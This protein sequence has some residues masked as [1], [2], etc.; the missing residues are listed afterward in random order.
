MVGILSKNIGRKMLPEDRRWASALCGSVWREP[1]NR[2]SSLEGTLGGSTR[3]DPELCMRDVL[4][5]G[6]DR[7]FPW[8]AELYEGGCRGRDLLERRC[9]VYRA[10]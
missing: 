1:L 7:K 2:H 4:I 9:V 3:W 5:G 6:L 8:D 10:L